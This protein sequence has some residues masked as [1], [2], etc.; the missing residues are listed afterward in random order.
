MGKK[1]FEA[2]EASVNSFQRN[3]SVEKALN[4]NNRSAAESDGGHPSGSKGGHPSSSDDS[5]PTGSDHSRP[6]GSDGGR[7]TGS[8]GGHQ[9]G[10]NGGHPPG[11]DGSHPPASDGSHPPASDGSHPP[12]SDG[13]HPPASDG[14]H[15]PGS[16]G[17][18][19]TESNGSHPTESNGSHP[20]GS[21]GGHPPASDG[22]HLIRSNGD[23]P[24]EREDGRSSGSDKSHPFFIEVKESER[25]VR[26][27]RKS[28]AFKDQ[29]KHFF[30]PWAAA[31]E[32]GLQKAK[33]SRPK[34]RGFSLCNFRWS[35]REDKERNLRK[36]DVLPLDKASTLTGIEK[37]ENCMTHLT[38]FTLFQAINNPTIRSHEPTASLRALSTAPQLLSQDLD[39]EHGLQDLSPIYCILN[40]RDKGVGNFNSVSYEIKDLSV[41]SEHHKSRQD[42]LSRPGTQEKIIK[43]HWL[44]PLTQHRRYPEDSKTI[45]VA[46]TRLP[47]ILPPLAVNEN[48]KAVAF[49][50]LSLDLESWMSHL[51]S[52]LKDIPINHL[53]IPGSHDSFSYSLT[54]GEEVG[55]D[56]PG[57]I[58]QLDS[59]MPCVAR[60]AILRWCVTQRASVTDQ[61]RHGIR[62]FD[63]RVAVRRSRFYFVHGLFGDDLEPILSE[64]RHF[65][66]RHPGEVVLLDFQHFHGLSASDHTSLVAFVEQV[67]SDLLCPYFHRV[68]HLSLSYL[69][70]SKYQVLVFYRHSE[71]MQAVSWLWSSA[72]LPNPWPEATTVSRM[73]TF[74]EAKLQE[75]DPAS[76]FVTQCVLTPSLAY[77]A[78]NVFARLERAMVA[79]TN[80]VIPDWLEKLSNEP[81]GANIIMADFVEHDNWAVPRAIVRKNSSSLLR[82]SHNKY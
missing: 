36:V 49:D 28:N 40:N 80:R 79:P 33:T 70:H 3:L 35:G 7:P 48:T 37:N 42:H 56:A 60:P 47:N 4:R 25:G 1:E 34:G 41:P 14:S 29:A 66:V 81:P 2:E 54:E 15:L 73:L 68:H 5:H 61:L 69:S 72:S 12:A 74:L 65:L 38:N 22:N 39:A 8:D 17:S 55:P 26:C 78:R 27:D 51:P 18:H 58:S 62:Y 77:V 46:T 53:F 16:N 67:F 20:T 63:I 76:F 30:R 13:S 59:C 21:N 50:V 9:I 6:T 71:T 44:R 31:S 64:I 52:P 43:H 23:R 45:F 32:P 11:S 57:L 82:D 75:R 19:P 24:L 10:S